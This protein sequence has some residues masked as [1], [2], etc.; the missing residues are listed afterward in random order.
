MNR[1][2]FSRRDF[3]R[4]VSSLGIST[5]LAK[6]LN[7][8]PE[9]D[10]AFAKSREALPPL[11][12]DL[13]VKPIKGKKAAQ[14][15]SQVME[16]ADALALRGALPA[17][18]EAVL[19]EARVSS[20][21][22]ARGTQ[23]AIIVSVPF[24]NHQGEQAVLQ[25]ITLNGVTESVMAVIPGDLDTTQA[26]IYTVVDEQVNVIDTALAASPDVAAA[27]VPPTCT[28]TAVINC[29]KAS[30]CSGLALTMCITSL[31]TCP[32]TVIG[33]IAATVCTAYCGVSFSRC[34]CKLCG[35]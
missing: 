19:Q 4:I 7:F 33:C 10:P 27:A 24:V 32:W 16:S 2:S 17:E 14:I 30:G 5:A 8:F 6:L 29:V 11:P 26:K 22:W 25:Q 35:C 28:R 1:K 23:N 15:L 3:F 31:L 9:V 21:T 20:A 34:W 18:F 13:V 12:P